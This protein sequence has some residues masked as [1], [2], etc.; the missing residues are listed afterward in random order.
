MPLEGLQIGRYHITRLLGSGG[1]GEVYLAED[2]RIEQQVAIKVIRGEVNPY[3]HAPEAEK[4]VRLFQREARAIAKLDHPRILSLFDYGEEVINGLTLIYIVMPFRQE[5]SL[6][7]WLH[8]RGRKELLLP[9]EVAHIINQAADALQHAHN[10][11]IIH[12][13]VKPSNFL[14]RSRQET[15]DYPDVL[16]ADFGIAKLITA[17]SSTSQSVRGTPVY[18]S[19]EQCNGIPVPASDQYALAIMAYELLTGQPPW[20]GGAVQVMYQH[21]HTQPQP[22]STINVR[23][24]A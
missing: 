10:H 16:L 19:P 12:Q 1:M 14:V 11:Q 8:Q 13:D 24:P 15:P 23:L 22:P 21:L 2:A 18:M 4:A 17:T 20:K 3:P 9:Q 5:G 6:A 7:D